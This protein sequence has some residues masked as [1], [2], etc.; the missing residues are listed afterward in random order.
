VH[1]NLV[2]VPADDVR[3]QRFV[4]VF[5][6]VTELRRKEERIHHMAFHD[7]LTGLPNRALVMDRLAEAS[8]K[9][10][11]REERMAL[12]FIDLDGITDCP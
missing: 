9:A 10:L 7:P 11:L 5:H 1:C 6:D 3:P 12:L 4:G 8:R 2:Q